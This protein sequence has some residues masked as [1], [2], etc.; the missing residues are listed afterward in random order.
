MIA[1]CSIERRVFSDRVDAVVVR[2][3]VK[4]KPI[5]PVVLL[6]REEAAKKVFNRLVCPFGLTIG[7]S[8]IH[9][10]SSR[11][12]SELSKEKR[13]EVGNEYHTVIGDS[14]LGRARECEV[15]ASSET[16]VGRGWVVLSL[17]IDILSGSEACSKIR[18]GTNE[19]RGDT[20]C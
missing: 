11:G 20:T 7:L 10:R 14:F 4:G 6:I 12:G 3:S 8:L 18:G 13:E 15:V 17:L 1:S 16:I 9:S 2:K 19:D 5:G